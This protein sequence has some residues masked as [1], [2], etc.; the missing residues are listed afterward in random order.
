MTGDIT[1]ILRLCRDDPTVATE[2]LLP[3]VYDSLRN[4][5]LAK[6]SR[7]R[8]E[9]T[10]QPTALVHETYLRLLHDNEN[11]NW[12]NRRHFFAAAAEA[13]RRILIERAR[14]RSRVRHGGHLER[15]N[16]PPD[17]VAMDSVT[18]D[19]DQR[20]LALDEALDRLASSDSRKGQVVKLRYF[21][22]FSIEDTARL[23][24]VSPTTVKSDWTIARAWLQ[25]EVL[26]A[27]HRMMGN[28]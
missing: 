24:G 9:H 10:L 12:E 6:M 13:M 25:R 22:G 11:W 17:S 26:A 5:A 2:R 27:Q 4:L 14:R 15:R 16:V 3:L 1:E 8:D 7:E 28:G 23:L 19:S 21:L 18:I 20:L